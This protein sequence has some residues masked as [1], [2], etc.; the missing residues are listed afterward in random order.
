MGPLLVDAL[1]VVVGPRPHNAT[2]SPVY[3]RFFDPISVALPFIGGQGA[4]HHSVAGPAAELPSLCEVHVADVA[5][6]NFT[7]RLVLVR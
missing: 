1:R 5:L 3:F 7:G 6:V 2:L 4:F